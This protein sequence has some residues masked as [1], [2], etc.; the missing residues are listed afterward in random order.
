MPA[1]KK[2]N[3]SKKKPQKSKTRAKTANQNRSAQTEQS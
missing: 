1:K 3:R 2:P